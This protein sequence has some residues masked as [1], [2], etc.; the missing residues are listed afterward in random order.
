[1]NIG[2]QE[3]VII[4]LIFGLLAVVWV[5][6]FWFI[7][8]KTGLSPWLSLMGLLPFG[9]LLLP[10]ILAFIDWPALKREP[11]ALPHTR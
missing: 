8:K 1:M 9:P 2:A 3:L 5:L 4:F 7:C 6:P 11:P 10:F